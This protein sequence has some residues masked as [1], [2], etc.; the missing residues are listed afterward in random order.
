MLRLLLHTFDDY[1]LPGLGRLLLGRPQPHPPFLD[2]AATHPFDLA[3]ATDTGGHIPGGRLTPANL[4][5]TAYYAI[6]PS[7]LTQAL[8]LLPEP[9]DGLTF[10]D[11]GCGKGRAPLVAARF[12]FTRILGVEL[13]PELCVIARANT[14]P[15]PRISI[16]Q[17][18]AATVLYPE[19]PLLVFLYH[20]FLAPQLRRVL[21]NLERQRRP[22]P[23]PTWLLYANPSYPRTMARFPFLQPLWDHSVPLSAEDA[24]ADRHRITHE[25]YTLYRSSR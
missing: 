25:R 21:A 13:S 11:L 6:S 15:H 2:S 9:A 16:Q 12:P 18:D 17:A 14:S 3:H 5:N 1:G 7:T 4:Y 19:S 23:H 22:S 24:A 20:P 8:Q 10:I